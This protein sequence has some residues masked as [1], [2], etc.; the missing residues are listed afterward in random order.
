MFTQRGASIGLSVALTIIVG[1][2]LVWDRIY[3]GPGNP[4]RPAPAPGALLVIEYGGVPPRPRGGVE[5]ETRRALSVHRAQPDRRRQEDAELRR[6][7]APVRTH[8][9][10]EGESLSS[11][12][13]KFY[14]QSSRWPEIA[15]ANH[16]SEPFLI[17]TGETLKIP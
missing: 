3:R 8:R 15:R 5:R 17:R 13:K 16:L 4:P 14:R 11:I 12:A 6:T 1:G 10:R 9:V 7:P 2:A